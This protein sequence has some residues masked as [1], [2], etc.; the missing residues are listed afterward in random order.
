M[1]VTDALMALHGTPATPSN[2]FTSTSATG[3]QSD[4]TLDFGAPVSGSAYPYLTEFPSIEE[5]GYTFPPEV[6]GDGGVEQGVHLIISTAVTAGSGMTAGNVIVSA[7]SANT[8]GT[9]L[10]QRQ[11][12]L[13]QLAV[14]GAHYFIPVP[15]AARAAYEFLGLY[16]QA[17]TYAAGAGTGYAWYGPKTGGEQ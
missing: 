12:T 3:D 8:L 2:I 6:V 17:V 7:G 4:Y 16:F 10:I 1:P 5:A 11:L 13:A 9:V 14:V 15:G